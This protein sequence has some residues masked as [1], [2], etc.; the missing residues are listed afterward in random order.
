L[1]RFFRKCP[2]GENAPVRPPKPISVQKQLRH[3]GDWADGVD[4]EALIQEAYQKGVPFKG[5]PDS[6]IYETGR[7]VGKNG[8]TQV[9]VRVAEKNIHGHP[10]AK[11]LN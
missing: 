8:E 1:A 9:I 2:K 4:P 5:R 6:L 10:A 11:V 3:A 7:V